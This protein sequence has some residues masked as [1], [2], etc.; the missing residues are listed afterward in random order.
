M[1]E[2][3]TTGHTTAL[4]YTRHFFFLF[5]KILIIRLIEALLLQVENDVTM[6]YAEVLKRIQKY[7]AGL[8]QND[9]KPRDHVGVHLNNSMEGF[10]AMYS[11][12]C[13][14]GIAV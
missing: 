8:Q 7:S 5:F 6:S 2:F 9:V 11:V 1:V 12:V 13:A 4:L 3:Y 10:I 14:G